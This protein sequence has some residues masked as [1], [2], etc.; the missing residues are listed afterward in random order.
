MIRSMRLASVVLT[1]ALFAGSGSDV[2]AWGGWGGDGGS[3]W[4][5]PGGYANWF[6]VSS[7]AT[8][9]IPVPPYFAIHPPVYY[10]QPVPR[11]YG[12]SPWAYPGDVMTPEPQVCAEPAII[13]NPYTK[14]MEE[15]S[16]QGKKPETN[17]T[18]AA[19]LTIDNPFV[20]GVAQAASA[21]PRVVAR[22]R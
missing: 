14:P 19:P 18:A 3:F 9:R 4:S 20:S 17:D 6:G 11:A 7:Y 10:S 5:Y 16:S 12:F 8:G 13:E 1:L 21:G 2:L 22:S 15:K